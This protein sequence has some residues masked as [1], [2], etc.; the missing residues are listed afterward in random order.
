MRGYGSGNR[1]GNGN[2]TGHKT[3]HRTGTGSENGKGT[4]NLRQ[5]TQLWPYHAYTFVRTRYILHLSVCILLERMAFHL[6]PNTLLRWD[7]GFSV[8]LVIAFSDSAAT[9][10]CVFLLALGRPA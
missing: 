6:P 7:D 10:T 4:V 3:R 8:R 5:Y 9:A 1:T 2:G